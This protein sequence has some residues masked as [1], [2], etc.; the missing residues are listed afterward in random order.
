M[1]RQRGQ[2]IDK[3]MNKHLLR[4]FLGTVEVTDPKTGQTKKKNQYHSE[5]FQGTISEA[6]KAL[7]QVVQKL[8]AKTFVRPTKRTVKDWCET[9]LDTKKPGLATK[10][11]LE[12]KARLEKCVYPFIGGLQLSQLSPEHLRILYGK[13]QTD[14]KLGPRMVGYTHQVLTGAL[15]VAEEDGVIASNPAA[16]KSVLACVPSRPTKPKFTILTAEEQQ[17]I[18][19]HE[20]DP[21]FRLLWRVFLVTWMRPQ[22]LQALKWSDLYDGAFHIVRAVETVESG[23]EVVKEYPKTDAGIRT[24]H[25]D[26]ETQAQLQTHKTEQAKAILKAG[27]HYERNGF[28]FATAY[29]TAFYRSSL[30]KRWKSLL[31]DAE[32]PHRHLYAMRHTGISHSMDSG[33]NPKA[34]SERA[35]HSNPAFTLSRYTHTLEGTGKR[36]AEGAAGVL[37][38]VN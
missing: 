8:D 4:V 14:L 24:I 6:K 10:T 26:D 16:K 21:Q 11:Y 18:L 37:R 34:V 32:V 31:I 9:W 25:L 5:L 7:T 1:R 29:G 23:K 36:V 35:G 3:G 27:E 22:E 38:K 12:Y 19:E 13:L 17:T 33:E 15:S 28:I 30:S 2:I 20:R